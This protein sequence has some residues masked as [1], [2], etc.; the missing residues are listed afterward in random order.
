[1][2]LWTSEDAAR[3]TGGRSAG[4]W[5]ARRVSIDSRRIEPGDLFVALTGEHFDGH[6]F[7]AQALENGAAA[8]MVSRAPQ[9]ADA[10]R[11]LVVPDT[12]DGLWSLAR[13]ARERTKARIAAVTGSV[14][15]TSTKEML[16]LGLSAH[17]RTFASFGNFN[18]HIGAPLNL[19]NLSPDA[20]FGVFE[21]GM[22]HAG[23]I[24]PLSR[25][26]R[27][28]AAAITNIEAVHLEF[29]S[30]LEGIADA[31]AEIFEGVEPDGAVLLN[32]DN[33]QFARLK[34]K[35]EEKRLR[36]LSFG[37]KGA[38]IRLISAQVEDGHTMIIVEVPQGRMQVALGAAGAH[39]AA[40]ALIALGMAEIFELEVKRSADALAEFAEPEGRGRIARLPW[41]EG[42][43]L[44]ID[45][46]YNAGPASMKAAFDKTAAVAAGRR[47]VAALGDMRELGE[48]APKL[49]EELAA[50]LKEN[51]FD[52]VFC[53]GTLMKHLYDALPPQMRGGYA[54][55]AEELLTLL[56]EAL[57]PGDLLLI[58]GSHG[59]LMYR[60]AAKFLKARKRNADAA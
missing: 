10:G 49:H 24:A 6:D 39:F 54:A 44:V 41:H 36:I 5:Q 16:K 34:T 42:E 20:K 23:E 26:V 48:S 8:A 52:A 56:E 51:G 28:H 1:M 21:L 55:S 47:K 38:D 46:S 59:S 4:G 57:R 3:A 35:A 30:G 53:A 40:S 2:T 25:L 50:S 15:K 12:L 32:A 58:K 31:K 60:L 37:R 13:A 17:G 19:A 14:G 11:L 43:L 45:D 27:P 18:N 33:A 9:G 7:A 22:N 29:F